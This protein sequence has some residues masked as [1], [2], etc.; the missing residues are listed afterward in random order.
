MLNFPPFKNQ[1]SEYCVSILATSK[2]IDDL[3]VCMYVIFVYVHIF[4][5]VQLAVLVFVAHP[6]LASWGH[7]KFSSVF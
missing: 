4:D 1:S 6:F 3:C 7:L 5:I 2:E